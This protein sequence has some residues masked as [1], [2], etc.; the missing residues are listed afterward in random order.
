MFTI[1]EL[2]RRTGLPV[3]TIRFY[4]D[5][6]LLPP[7]DRT[8]AGYRLY[9]I[10]SLARLELVRTLRELGLG[11]RDVEL[12]LT[13]QTSVTELAQL[14]IE[15]LDEQIR[16]LTLRRAVLRAVV[17]RR[18]ELEEIRLMNELASMPDEERGRLLEDFWNEVTEGLDMDPAFV[19]QMRAARPAL[20][21]DPTPD[22]LEAWIEFGELVRDPEFRRLIRELN[23][24]HA[25]ARRAGESMAPADQP[26]MDGLFERA[27]SAL[28]E[29]TAPQ[30]AAGRAVADELARASAPADR[31]PDDPEYRR[32]LAD[33]FARGADRRAERYWQLLAI[34]NGWPPIP[35]RHAAAEWVHEALR[36]TAAGA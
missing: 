12:A 28:A 26:D 8:H 3:K 32:E 30:S 7:T 31:D 11:L 13:A 20:P 6:G 1:G 27:E 29:G 2:A 18:S 25:D 34:M 9:D 14:H 33:R 4:S 24:K 35:S 21:D 15:T 10:P 5:E 19:Q 17:K 23:V 16:K 36:A 22:Q